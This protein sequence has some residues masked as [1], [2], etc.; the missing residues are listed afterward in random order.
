M[1]KEAS[2]PLEGII[3]EIPWVPNIDPEID[4]LTREMEV[5]PP[6]PMDVELA[7]TTPTVALPTLP[8]IVEEEEVQELPVLALLVKQANIKVAKKEE[9]I[10]TSLPVIKAIAKVLLAATKLLI[11]KMIGEA[12]GKPTIGAH[13][14]IVTSKAIEEVAGRPMVGAREVIVTLMVASPMPSRATPCNDHR[15]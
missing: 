15:Q 13:K 7:K 5:A 2:A 6:I 4:V 11:G 9:P 8:I 3:E 10:A 1:V 14:V 12:M